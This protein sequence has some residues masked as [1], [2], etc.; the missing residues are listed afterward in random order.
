MQLY[1]KRKGGGL[2]IKVKK[3]I[4]AKLKNKFILCT[5]L[6]YDFICFRKIRE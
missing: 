5:Q 2:T 4:F 3:Y 1:K 6:V